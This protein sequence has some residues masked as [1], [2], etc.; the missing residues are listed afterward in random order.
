MPVLEG[1]IKV[2]L[3]GGVSNTDPKES[4]GGTRSTTQV[5]LST[6]LNN[7]FDNVSAAENAGGDFSEY[8]CVALKNE[9]SAGDLTNIKAYVATII[10]SDAVGLAWEDTIN[11]TDVIAKTATETTVPS[12]TGLGSFTNNPV[13]PGILNNPRGSTV[14]IAPTQVTR[15]WLRRTHTSGSNSGTVQGLTTVTGE[16]S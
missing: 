13:S 1:D 15:L 12:G 6:L 4:R 9:A 10:T 2:Y 7:L 16:T 14:T 3:T 5:N 8:R 11:D